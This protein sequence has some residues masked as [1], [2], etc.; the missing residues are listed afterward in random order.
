MLYHEKYA[1]ITKEELTRL[2]KEEGYT[3]VKCRAHLDY[4]GGEEVSYYGTVIC[5]HTDKPRALFSEAISHDNRFGG[6]Y[7]TTYNIYI[8]N[9]YGANDIDKALKYN[10][11]DVGRLYNSVHSGEYT[12]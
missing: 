11:I 2:V 4:G 12:D 8:D 9:E 1:N 7:N 6:T 3:V 5:S 10:D